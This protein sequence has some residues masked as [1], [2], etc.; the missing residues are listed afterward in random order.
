[1]Q[2]DDYFM[3][4]LNHDD[5]V[6]LAKKKYKWAFDR[7]DKKGKALPNI[8]PNEIHGMYHSYLEP[9]VCGKRI[10]DFKT[11]LTYDDYINRIK[12]GQVIM[13]SGTFPDAGLSGHAFC[14]IGIINNGKQN[15]LVADP[16]GDYRTNY[17]RVKGY[18]I[19]MSEEDWYKYTKP[20]D[21]NKKWGHIL[22]EVNNE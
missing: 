2:D 21:K 3:K 15:L 5:A 19:I 12:L 11:D 14:I 10:S 13:T 7:K 4:L 16:W 1:M 8:P 20:T 17:H 18:N 6:K 9:I 22:T